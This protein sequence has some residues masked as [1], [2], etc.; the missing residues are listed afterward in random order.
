MMSCNI[1]IHSTRFRCEMWK[2][3]RRSFILTWNGVKDEY[4]F[5][6][7]L[8]INTFATRH[9]WRMAL[10]QQNEILSVFKKK[11]VLFCAAWSLFF[12]EFGQYCCNKTGKMSNNWTADNHVTNYKFYSPHLWRTEKYG[13]TSLL[14]IKVLAKYN[15]E[16]W[17]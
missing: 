16:T 7:M 5:T 3:E 12:R 1:G 2:K 17:L 13:W 9:I 11:T 4:K 6:S 8:S 10:F 14:F 15:S